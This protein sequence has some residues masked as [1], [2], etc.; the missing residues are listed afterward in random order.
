MLGTFDCALDLPRADELE[1]IGTEGVLR[2]PDPWLC[3]AGEIILTRDGAPER[4]P[5]D[6]LG[7]TGT[8]HD[9]YR[10][11]FETFDEVVAGERPAPFGR[12]DAVAQ[13]ATLEG[14]RQ[15]ATTGQRATF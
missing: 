3:R 7:L 5:V 14:L 11:E 13:A 10:I 8:D 2:I 1:V 15:A 6:H 9:A 4:V 12:D